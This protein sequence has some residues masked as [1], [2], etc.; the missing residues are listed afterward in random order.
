VSILLTGDRVLL[1]EFV[2][3]DWRAVHAYDTLPEIYR[4]QPWGPNTPEETRAYVDAVIAA[5]KAEPRDRYGLAIVLKATG[6]FI[7]ACEL[8]IKDRRFRA[9][10]IG[11]VLH[12]RHWGHG[13]AT[14]AARL[15]LAFGFGPQGLHRIQATC[16]PQNTASSRVLQRLG[17]QY[18]GRMRETML[19]RDGWR[20]S[21][22]YSILEAEWTQ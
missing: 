2:P 18:E 19:L 15:L 1:R 5:S 20:D 16:H 9:G 13:Y 10:E 14:E 3:D 7:G 22:L 8:K 17:M 21:D 12:S 11:Y 6:V 4:F